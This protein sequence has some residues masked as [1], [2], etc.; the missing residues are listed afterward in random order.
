MLIILYHLKEIKKIFFF[1]LGEGPSKEHITGSVSAAEIKK[2]PL[3]MQIH[4]FTLQ[5]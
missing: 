3:V 4:N 5:R 1:V 2:L